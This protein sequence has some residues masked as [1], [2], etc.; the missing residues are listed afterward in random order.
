MVTTRSQTK[1]Q[2]NLMKEFES[3]VIDI[4]TTAQTSTIGDFELIFDF[5]YASRSWRTN[6]KLI[7]NG[8]FHYICGFI[9]KDGKPCKNP[10]HCRIHNRL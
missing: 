8:T 2:N 5:D 4:D 1:Y 3:S 10:T 6:K 7:G 9:K